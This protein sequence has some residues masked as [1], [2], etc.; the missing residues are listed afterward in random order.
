MQACC[1]AE[2]QCPCGT[3]LRHSGGDGSS[4]PAAQLGPALSFAC[5]SPTRKLANMSTDP[6][7]A[8]AAGVPGEGRREGESQHTVDP[9]EIGPI[10][11][12]GNGRVTG[13]QPSEGGRV[14]EEQG[15]A[16]PEPPPPHKARRSP[17]ATRPSPLATTTPQPPTFPAPSL[18]RAAHQADGVCRWRRGEG[19]GPDG[20]LGR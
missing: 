19:A 5:H 1:T 12:R 14:A 6:T 7:M 9:T 18:P 8:P 2:G 3:A 20:A 11:V 17:A 15:S 13:W 16:P 10:E 4:R